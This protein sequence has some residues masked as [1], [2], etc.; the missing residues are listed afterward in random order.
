MLLFHFTFLFGLFSVMF[1]LLV[2]AFIFVYTERG[3][4]WL[5]SLDEYETDE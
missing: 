4:R 2:A 1:V 3:R 5:R